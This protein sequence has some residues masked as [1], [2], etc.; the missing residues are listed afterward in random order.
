MHYCQLDHPRKGPGNTDVSGRFLFD[1]QLDHDQLDT[2]LF[3]KETKKSKQKNT[4]PQFS[5]SMEQLSLPLIP[6]R[7]TG[8]DVVYRAQSLRRIDTD[9]ADITLDLLSVGQEEER[10]L[11]QNNNLYPSV[12]FTTFGCFIIGDRF[13][14]AQAFG[15]YT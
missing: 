10:R 7:R 6:I 12:F 8:H 3:Q 9:M 4:L 14:L 5:L 15:R 11:I 2:P 13:C 1:Y